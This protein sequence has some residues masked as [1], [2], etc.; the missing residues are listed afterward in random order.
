MH[1]GTAMT[2]QAATCSGSCWEHDWGGP[3]FLLGPLFWVLVTIG[4]IW[5]VRRSRR[6]Y[7]DSINR[8]GGGIRLLECRY[9]QGEVTAE[10][11]RERRCVL[12]EHRLRPRRGAGE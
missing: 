11:Y 5:L 7:R 8:R 10:E 12:E 4:I 3:W 9:A 6:R 2:L 1:V